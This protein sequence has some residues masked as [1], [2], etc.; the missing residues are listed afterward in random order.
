MCERIATIGLTGGIAAGKSAAARFFAQL[1]I[2]IVDADRIA[3]EVVFPGEPTLAAV[4]E[5]FGTE[6]LATDGTLAR[7]VLAKRVFADET[8]RMRLNAIM[9]PA[10]GARSVEQL[11]T[12]R[13]RAQGE[14]HR[15]VIYE[16]P[17]LIENKIHESMAGVI[18]VDVTEDI[19]RA[20][21]K[22]RDA[23]SD[24][25]IEARLAAQMPIAEKRTYATWLV[26]NSGSL[27]QLRRNVE[28][29]H[30]A[31]CQHLQ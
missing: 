20:R 16:A 30:N 27:A 17:L 13:K 8:A 12:A 1:G 3:R 10:I 25:E 7:D 6:V 31:I 24:A 22:T 2:R 14:G 5:A 29:T 4:V 18:V 26:D 23:L 19:Q 9:H 28:S 21:L 11:D 15:Y